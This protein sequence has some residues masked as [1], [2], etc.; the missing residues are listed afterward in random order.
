M[1]LCVYICT[2]VCEYVL[3]RKETRAHPTTLTCI[4]TH[5]THTHRSYTYR[6]SHPHAHPHKL[7]HTYTYTYTAVRGCSFF[8]SAACNIHAHPHT[9]LHTL[10]H[11]YTYTCTAVRGCSFFPSAARKWMQTYGTSLSAWSI[12]GMLLCVCI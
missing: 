9:Y 5:D 10:T 3:A 12:S 6:H 7:T 11:T 4:Y 2:L 8:S 1:S